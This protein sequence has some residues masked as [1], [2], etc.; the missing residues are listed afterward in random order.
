MFIYTT[1]KGNKRSL[2]QEQPIIHCNKHIDSLCTI[3]PLQG[4]E[5]GTRNIL[6]KLYVTFFPPTAGMNP[7]IMNL[8]V[9]VDYMLPLRCPPHQPRGEGERLHLH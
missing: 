5:K 6:C 4:N 9:Y 1:L 8:G 3:F 7:K 2:G